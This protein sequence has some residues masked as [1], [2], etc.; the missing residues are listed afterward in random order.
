MQ[1]W[2]SFCKM[3]KKYVHI[4]DYSGWFSA[5]STKALFQPSEEKQSYV[6][7]VKFKISNLKCTTQV[8]VRHS[9]Q[10]K[11]IG[12]LKTMRWLS[13]ILLTFGL[14]R[15]YLLLMI[16]GRFT[17]F[18]NRNSEPALLLTPFRMTMPLSVLIKAPIVTS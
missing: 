5:I 4:V 16:G 11:N 18:W 10:F 2:S 12:Y 1:G 15:K 13:L 6:A 7:M 9:P 8:S 3:L 14:F 17:N